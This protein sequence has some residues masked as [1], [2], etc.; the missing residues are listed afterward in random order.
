MQSKKTGDLVHMTEAAERPRQ[1][2]DVRTEWLE[3]GMVVQTADGRAA[4]LL[5][6]TAAHIWERCNG[7]RTV[8]AIAAQLAAETGADPARV[9]TDVSA[10]VADLREK[11]LVE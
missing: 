9:Q 5:N 7:T 6:R 4:H 8:E 2:G 10:A 11:G 1:R 3:D